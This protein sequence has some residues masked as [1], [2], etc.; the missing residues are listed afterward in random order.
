MP[1]HAPCTR[2]VADQG[3]PST[4][5][6]TYVWTKQAWTFVQRPRRRWAR[7][8][9]LRRA[10]WPDARPPCGPAVLI[11][12]GP[13]AVAACHLPGLTTAGRAGGAL[14]RTHLAHTPLSD[15]SAPCPRTDISHST[16]YDTGTARA[17]YA[18]WTHVDR[19]II[20]RC[21]L[22]LSM[23][24]RV[25]EPPEAACTRPEH[26][27]LPLRYLTTL[28]MCVR[29]HAPRTNKVTIKRGAGMR[30]VH[31]TPHMLPRQNTNG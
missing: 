14:T 20:H 31:P 13:R 29:A 25:K 15:S 17:A 27:L 2:P 10:G 8:R 26:L 9:A 7:L 22:S 11:P 21:F 5:A 4:P 1:T 16:V 30:F 18:E 23:Q 6:R 12:G 19:H 24:W 3:A 28:S